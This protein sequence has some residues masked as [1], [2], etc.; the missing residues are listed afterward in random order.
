MYRPIPSGGVPAKQIETINEY[1]E[2]L[3]IHYVDTKQMTSKEKKKFLLNTD[4]K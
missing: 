2:K 1:A 4:I 3:K